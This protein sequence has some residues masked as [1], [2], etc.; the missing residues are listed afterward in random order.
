MPSATCREVRTG[1]TD[2]AKAL[3]VIFDAQTWP[4]IFHQ[5]ASDPVADEEQPRFLVETPT[6]TRL[7]RQDCLR[8]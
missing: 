5:V 2:H 8:T 1:E 6:P 4:L 3:E 7:E